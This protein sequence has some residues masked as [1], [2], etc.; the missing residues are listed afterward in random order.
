MRD[1]SE[2][3]W[4]LIDGY[5]VGD[6]A[7]EQVDEVERWI[8]ANP[9]HRAVI[10]QLRKSWPR[11]NK[12]HQALNLA[13]VE[14]SILNTIASQASS[15]RRPGVGTAPT[16]AHRR[17]VASDARSGLF[18]RWHW[19]G[20]GAALAAAVVVFAVVTGRRPSSSAPGLHGATHVYRTRTGQV[21]T[22]VLSD[23]SRVQLAPR[24]TL[25][26]DDA[27]GATTRTVA[28]SGEAYFDVQHTTGAPFIVT[29]GAINTRVLGTTFGL[30]YGGED[31]AVH[32][33]VT[34]GRVAVARAS[35]PSAPLTLSAGMIGLVTDSSAVT[36]PTSA[37]YVGW[38]NGQLV[39]HKA[40]TAEVLASLSR[41]Y[42]YQFRLADSSLAHQNLTLALSTESSSVA[43]STLKL[44]M[45]VEL[46]FDHNVVTLH[47]RVTSHAMPRLIPRQHDTLFPTSLEVGR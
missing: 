19:A 31:S 13:A 41:W 20:V 37:S 32:V 1:D 36:L 33:V 27:F 10:D 29:T 21:A 40:T 39:F 47:P 34:A 2:L 6:L 4:T 11:V 24:T 22:V 8:G 18:Q 16:S 23:G 43:L 26:V 46:T 7:P 25:S 45:D 35:A 30:R 28:L 3:D 38:I 42:G 5:L 15:T 14:Q 44:M 17:P 9:E 12:R